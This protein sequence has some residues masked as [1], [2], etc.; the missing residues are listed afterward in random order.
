MKILLIKKKIFQLSYE[1]LITDSNE[2]I[3]SLI[4][5]CELPWE[6]QCLEFYNNK[7]TVKTASVSQVRKKIYKSSSKKWENFKTYLPDLF[8]NLS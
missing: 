7:N 6:E 1:N 4:N 2:T 3:K 8:D 5:Y